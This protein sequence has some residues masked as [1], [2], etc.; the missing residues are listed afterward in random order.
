MTVDALTGWLLE[1]GTTLYAY[2]GELYVQ[3]GGTACHMHRVGGP[4]C[5]ADCAMRADDMPAVLAAHEPELW[6]ILRTEPCCATCYDVDTETWRPDWVAVDAA[7]RPYLVDRDAD[8][9]LHST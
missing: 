1:H 2:Q 8:G 5:G 6:Q 3:P 9:T 4:R 7:D